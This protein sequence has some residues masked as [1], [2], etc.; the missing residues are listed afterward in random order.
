MWQKTKN[1]YHLQ[2]AIIANI[3]YGFPSRG[4][5]IIGVTGT[6]GKTTTVN[7]I[8][9]LLHEAGIK[10][11]VISSVGAVIDGKK[12]DLA[13]HVT[14][15]GS[16]VIQSY[17]RKAKKAGVK[18]IVLEMTSHALDQ[19]RAH[20]VHIDVGVVTNISREHLDYHKTYKNYVKAKAK[21]LKKARI[22]ILNKD[23][24]SY[25]LLKKH[26]LRHFHNKLLTYGLKKD[27]DINPHV[28]PFQTKLL[29][30]FNKYNCLA[31]IAVLQQFHIPD[32][33]IRKG[34]LSFKPPAGRQDVI[35]NNDFMVINDFAH[36]PNSFSVILPE[37]RK[38]AIHRLIHVFGSAA[39]RD[40]YKRP[41]MGGISAKYSDI[42]VLTSEDQR[43]EPIESINKDILVGIKG[44]EVI[45]DVSEG[46][47]IQKIKKYVFV[48]P[49]RK[50]AIQFAI[51]LAQKGDVVLLTGKGHEK[52]INYGK[53]EEPWNESQFAKE[54]IAFRIAK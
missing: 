18:Y 43:D 6:D 31:A 17:I 37:L 20:G 26:E 42:I 36:T 40:K 8:Y 7:L 41:E 3:I 35:Y 49:D 5:K 21:L 39:K 53:G 15:P 45:K 47:A 25:L 48:I 32:I 44:F 23:D 19:Y 54:A 28:F 1:I 33:S 13:F 24:K 16:F 14:T 10:A 27:S 30:Q 12:F 11:A 50:E 38:L 29:G 22:A 34:L 2:Q 46:L 51:N 52:S 9:H 4:I